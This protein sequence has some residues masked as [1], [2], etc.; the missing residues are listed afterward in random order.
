KLA[1]VPK[2]WVAV[3]PLVD[4]KVALK[5]GARG[6][7]RL[8]AG[9]KIG[10]PCRGQRLGGGR[11]GVPVE[12]EAANAH[13]KATELNVDVGTAGQGLDRRLPVG[14]HLVSLAG[15]GAN[16]NRSTDVIEHDLGVGKRPCETG[17]F[18]DLRVI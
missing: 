18:I 15:I 13:A 10:T 9:F 2:H 1:G 4:R 8:D 3:G 11:L 12:I 6:P 16:A 14:K 5:H 7:E 17:K